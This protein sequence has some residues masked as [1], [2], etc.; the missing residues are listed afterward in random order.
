MYHTI[1]FGI[2]EVQR[3]ETTCGLSVDGVDLGRH[4]VL[5]R[6]RLAQDVKEWRDIE[7]TEMD[8]RVP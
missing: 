4:G 8:L 1:L 5:D 3:R 7:N 6:I 2:Y